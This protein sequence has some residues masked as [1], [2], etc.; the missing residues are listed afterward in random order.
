MNGHFKF[1]TEITQP[2]KADNESFFLPKD[3]HIKRYGKFYFTNNW[4]FAFQ[5]AGFNGI[6]SKQVI[7]NVEVKHT[8]NDTFL[9]N[10]V[11][12]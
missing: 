4:I 2:Y 3:T 12:Q 11:A 5:R 10:R 8:M 7:Q 6:F 1:I 9:S